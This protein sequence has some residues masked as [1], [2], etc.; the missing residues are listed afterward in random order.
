M[1][2]HTVRYG[3]RDA[4]CKKFIWNLHRDAD[5]KEAKKEGSG[6]DAI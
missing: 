4:T 5:R 3:R 1:G 6:P 2:M